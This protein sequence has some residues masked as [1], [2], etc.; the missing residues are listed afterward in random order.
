MLASWLYGMGSIPESDRQDEGYPY[1]VYDKY[2]ARQMKFLMQYP[3]DD[4]FEIN[5]V[6]RP[7]IYV[8]NCVMVRH[9]SFG[10]MR[11]VC[12]YIFVPQQI[13]TGTMLR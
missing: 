13:L 4:L 1:T 6:V 3:I 10:D 5:R 11:Y 9:D 12:E 7:L 2:Q 8:A